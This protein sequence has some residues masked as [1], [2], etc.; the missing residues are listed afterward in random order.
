VHKWKLKSLTQTVRPLQ[1]LRLSD[2]LFGREYNEELIHQLVLLT[3]QMRARAIASKKGRSE[4][5]K[6]TRKPWLKKVRAV[7][8]WYG[9]QPAMA[10]RRQDFPKY[11]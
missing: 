1:V 8:C 6:S 10:R 9:L 3:R 11:P 2:D 5:A 4:I 7:P